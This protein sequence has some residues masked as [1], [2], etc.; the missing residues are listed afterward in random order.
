MSVIRY[1][2]A[3]ANIPVLPALLGL[4]NVS[5]QIFLLRRM[6]ISVLPQETCGTIL[7]RESFVR[8]SRLRTKIWLRKSLL[9]AMVRQKTPLLRMKRQS[10]APAVCYK[11]VTGVCVSSLCSRSL[12]GNSLM[13]RLVY[14]GDSASL[15]FLQSIR[16]LVEGSLG[17]SAFTMDSNRHK[18]VEASISTPPGYRHTYALPDLEAA[19]YLT[20]SFFD[21]VSR[22]SRHSQAL[23]ELT[24]Y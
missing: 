6:P 11:M 20:D 10:K 19:R 8:S 12:R 22:A 9:I 7:Q 15:S 16:R 18:I 13:W 1:C 4:V 14:V 3:L 21:N 17:T 23:A 5:F 2:S 24:Y